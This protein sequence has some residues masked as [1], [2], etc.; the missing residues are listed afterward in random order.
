MRHIITKQT[1]TAFIM[2]VA[3]LLSTCGSAT[4]RHRRRHHHSRT[5]GALVG[6]GAGAVGGALL[7]GKKGAVIGAGAGAGT[8]YLIQTGGNAGAIDVAVNH[9]TGLQV[10]GVA[11]SMDGS[12][13]TNFVYENNLVGPDA[14]QA[15]VLD[16]WLDQVAI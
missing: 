4:A 10:N 14:F 2:C 3:L 15:G 13:F 5:K 7:G 11:L 6:G 16:G 12:A 8:G 1:I 9:N